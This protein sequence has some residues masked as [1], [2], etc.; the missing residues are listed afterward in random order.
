ML[1]KNSTVQTPLGK[2]V[3]QGGFTIYSKQEQAV[4]GVMVRLP[5]NDTT[6]AHLNKSNCLTPKAR[7]SGLWVF[8]ENQLQVK[9]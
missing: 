6:R 7:Y 3:V 4:R 8:E 9:T 2:G 5:V 1:A